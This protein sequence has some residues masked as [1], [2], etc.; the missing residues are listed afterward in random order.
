[1]KHKKSFDSFCTLQLTAVPHRPVTVVPLQLPD[2]NGS[3]DRE[4]AYHADELRLLLRRVTLRA[5]RVRCEGAC[6]GL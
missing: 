2:G 3:V 1:M 5:K 6:D 4:N